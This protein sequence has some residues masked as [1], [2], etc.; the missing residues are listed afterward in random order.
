M[1]RTFKRAALTTV[2]AAAVLWGTACRETP[3]GESL[4]HQVAN[5]NGLRLEVEV[6]K[7]ITP[8]GDSATVTTRLHN[9]NAEDVLLR[10][11]STCQIEPYVEDASGAVQYPRGGAWACGAMLT[12]LTVPGRGFV[13]RTFTVRGVASTAG[14][15][16]ASLAPGRY[17]VYALADVSLPLPQLGPQ[18]PL[19]SPTVEFEIR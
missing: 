17:R 6:D 2:V 3:T 10:F 11:G 5:L 7:A 19:R 18:P 13:T 8:V 9:S 16:G 12:S 4:P 15:L 14:P 1:I